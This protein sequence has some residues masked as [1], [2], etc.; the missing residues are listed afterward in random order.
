M[1]SRSSARRCCPTD[2]SNFR[3]MVQEFTGIPAPPFAGPS[4][5]R[6]GRFDHIFPSRSS[7]SAA[8]VL[9]QYLLIALEALLAVYP[10]AALLGAAFSD[11]L[12]L[13]AMTF[14]STA[15]LHA[16][17]VA[18]VARATLPRFF[19]ADLRGSAFQGL[20]RRDA[21]ER[22]VVMR[23]P[24]LLAEPFV[25]EYLGANIHVVGT[26]LRVVGR[27]FSGTVVSP[28]VAAGAD[29]SLGALV[30]VLGRDRI[31]DVGLCISGAAG[32]RK[33][34]FLQ[35]CQELRWT[36]AGWRSR[37]ESGE[38]VSAPPPPKPS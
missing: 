5:A 3:A 23:L 28:N 8:A 27:R 31:I 20:A 16:D 30:A 19:L 36:T 25:R 24:R 11:N 26:E 22:Y 34:A 32:D 15:G 38:E 9:P 13:L 21:G 29:Q 10:L 4:A 1:A 37:A 33:P 7:P 14:L 18:A 6:S 17:D 2:T 35:V 12:P